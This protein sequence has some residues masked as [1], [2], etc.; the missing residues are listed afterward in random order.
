MPRQLHNNFTDEQV[1]ALLKSY[2]AKKSRLIIF[3]KSLKS[4]EVDFL[5]YWLNTAYKA[6]FL[7]PTF[8]PTLKFDFYQKT[9][10]FTGLAQGFISIFALF[11]ILLF[12]C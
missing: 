3:C 6:R 10:S 12:I 4:K 8:V 11:G 1:K 5:D 9:C 7:G 2:L